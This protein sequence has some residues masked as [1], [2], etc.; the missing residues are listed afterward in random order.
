MSIKLHLLRLERRYPSVSRFLKIRVVF[1]LLR[2]AQVLM[3]FMRVLLFM[4]VVYVVL[5]FSKPETESPIVVIATRDAHIGPCSLQLIEMVSEHSNRSLVLSV[6]G[7]SEFRKINTQ[8]LEMRGIQPFRIVEQ[9][10]FQSLKLVVQAKAHFAFESVFE[11]FVAGTF[12]RV[13]ISN[14]QMPIVVPDGVVTKTNGNLIP[15]RKI[16]GIDLK[17][18]LIGLA[19]KQII[20]VSQ[21]GVDNYR[22]CLNTGVR[23]P[24]LMRQVG[25]PRFLRASGIIDENITPAITPSLRGKLANDTSRHRLIVALTKNREESDLEWFLVQIGASIEELT[26]TLD[27]ADCSIWIKS[28]QSTLPL[29]IVSGGC[30]GE[31]RK[32]IFAIGPEE[33]ISS[34]DIFPEFDALVTDISSIYVDFLPFDKPIGFLGFSKW[35]GES[36]FCYPNLPFYPGSHVETISEFEEFLEELPNGACGLAH[37]R[38]AARK[39]LLGDGTDRS[40]WSEHV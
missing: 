34:V 9:D 33:G 2:D 3:L 32:R 11:T 36:R 40:F 28:H 6:K 26:K 8:I 15:S 18:R 4:P 39:V 20:Y 31:Q 10:S 5:K 30:A 27:R 25:L 22:V 23:S 38:A 29:N 37:E 7:V 17:I 13:L 35:K 16:V 1:Y 12:R 24:S 21:S 19:A 14:A